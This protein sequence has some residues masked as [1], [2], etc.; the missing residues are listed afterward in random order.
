MQKSA[1]L[2]GDL[3]STSS[4]KSLKQVSSSSP[5]GVSREMVSWGKYNNN[6]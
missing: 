5:I 2:E 4:T 1:A 6:Y 3:A